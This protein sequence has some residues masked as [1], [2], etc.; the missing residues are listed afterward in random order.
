MFTMY[1]FLAN[2]KSNF[3]NFCLVKLVLLN[4]A[5]Y[6]QRFSYHYSHD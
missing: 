6:L 1:T 5:E 4:L 3:D 2:D